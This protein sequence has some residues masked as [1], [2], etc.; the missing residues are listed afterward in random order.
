MAAIYS[1]GGNWWNTFSFNFTKK[2]AL[3][4]V[5]KISL[6]ETLQSFNSF[7]KV[8]AAN[9]HRGLSI[10]VSVLWIVISVFTIPPM[11]AW[12]IP[13]SQQINIDVG[14]LLLNAVLT[15]LLPM[16]VSYALY[17]KIFYKEYRVSEKVEFS[18]QI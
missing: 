17:P 16:V 2:D 8:T 5:Y 14:K 6:G 11:I 4:S 9:G 10:L 3:S 15:I 18:I 12:L 13:S 7:F 1:N